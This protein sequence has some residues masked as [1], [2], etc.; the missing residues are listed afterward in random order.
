M[1]LQARIMIHIIFFLSRERKIWFVL[2]SK[3]CVFT[4]HKRNSD[5]EIYNRGMYVNFKKTLPISRELG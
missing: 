4:L 2:I 5:W 3:L 1:Q